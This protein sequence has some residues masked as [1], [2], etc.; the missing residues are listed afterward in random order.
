VSEDLGADLISRHHFPGLLRGSKF[1]LIV[2]SAG[3]VSLSRVLF[4][5]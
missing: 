4:A 3:D 5:K 1:Q 2:H